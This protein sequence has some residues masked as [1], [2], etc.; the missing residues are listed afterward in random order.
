MPDGKRIINAR[1]ETILEKSLFKDG[2]LQRRC[3]IPPA[4]TMSGR[5]GT[6]IRSS[7]HSVGRFRRV[8]HGRHIPHG[9]GHPRFRDL[10][11]ISPH[12]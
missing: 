4:A 12:I 7:I 1:S 2:M 11:R 6:E 3:L 9:E 8:V 10:H 5:S